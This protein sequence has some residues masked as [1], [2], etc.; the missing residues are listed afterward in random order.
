MISRRE[1]MKVSTGTVAVQ[2]LAIKALS[3]NMLQWSQTIWC[4]ELK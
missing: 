4:G 2:R 1:F 3:L